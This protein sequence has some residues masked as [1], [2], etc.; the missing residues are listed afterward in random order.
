MTI[1]PGDKVRLNGVER[2]SE[3]CWVV[4]SGGSVVVHPDMLVSSTAVANSIVCC[5]K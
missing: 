1:L 2:S 5:R 4:G 3:G